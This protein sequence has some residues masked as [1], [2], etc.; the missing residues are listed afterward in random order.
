MLLR[1]WFR[2]YIAGHPTSYYM[3]ENGKKMMFDLKL[4]VI[5]H[6]H[7]NVIEVHSE[8]N[9]KFKYYKE[10]ISGE[11]KYRKIKA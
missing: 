2:I 3:F 5:Q 8:N 6:V 7:K 4:H 11:K 9:E 1:A 10:C